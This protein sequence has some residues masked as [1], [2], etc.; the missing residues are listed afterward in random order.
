M[1]RLTG[2]TD[3]GQAQW[4][5]STRQEQ[6]PGIG[7]LPDRW[8]LRRSEKQIA[9]IRRTAQAT[10]QA[11]PV[12]DRLPSHLANGLRLSGGDDQP[13]S[14]WQGC[15]APDA[16]EASRSHDDDGL[17]RPVEDSSGVMD[18][19]ASISIVGNRSRSAPMGA[20]RRRIP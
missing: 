5:I 17:S 15:Q 18:S 9:R 4:E 16:R 12:M 8:M 6:E 20:R 7:K 19:A 14:L 1:T 3:G 2:G 13:T 10:N 11:G